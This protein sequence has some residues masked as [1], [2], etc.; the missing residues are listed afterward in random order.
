M[1]VDDPSDS[2]ASKFVYLNDNSRYLWHGSASHG[3]LPT[4]ALYLTLGG[5]A[6]ADTEETGYRRDRN[7]LS[8]PFPNLF[9]SIL[10]SYSS[11]K[12]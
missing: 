4:T 3:K 7:S 10:P 11:F 9:A 12:E 1:Y 5:T 8:F 2:L 6:F